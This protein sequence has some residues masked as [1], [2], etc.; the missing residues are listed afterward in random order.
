M[1]GR[2]G[3]TL[4][5]LLPLGGLAAGWAQTHHAAQ[6]G[7]EWKVPIAGYDPRDLL[8]G[9]YVIYT[10]DWPG[11]ADAPGDLAYQPALCLEGTAPVITRVYVPQGRLCPNRVEARGGL[12]DPEGGL[13]SGRLYVSQ[14]EGARLERQ[15][16][17]PALQ[18]FIRIRVRKDGHLTPL[19]LTFRPRPPE[20]PPSADAAPPSSVNTP[21]L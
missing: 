17:D 12:G 18:G 9:H 2:L 7:T 11:L 19:R 21:G 15:L 13:V 8:R 6:Q 14:T 1:N 10:Y 3:L 4:A 20:P 16:R 5:L